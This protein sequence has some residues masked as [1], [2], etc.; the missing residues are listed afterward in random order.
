[1]ASPPGE[2]EFPLSAPAAGMPLTDSALGYFAAYLT[3]VLPELVG[4]AWEEVNPGEPLIKT[5]NTWDPEEGPFNDD[6]LP[7]LYLWKP[8][9]QFGINEDWVKEADG[10]RVNEASVV[11]MWVLPPAEESQFGLMHPF[12]QGFAD[13][14]DYAIRLGRHSAWK[15]AA[16]SDP[17]AATMGSSFTTW[18]NWTK[19]ELTDVKRAT[20]ER[21]YTDSNE[22]DTFLAYRAEIRTASL[23]TNPPIEVGVNVWPNR[24][25]MTITRTDG[26]I[27]NEC[28]TP[29]PDQ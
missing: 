27:L 8:K 24:S 14:L 15:I 25:Y 22:L 26:V 29:V 18:C 6:E 13:A 1:M 10:A 19:C 21:G 9:V 3:A 12:I 5:C 20:I 16:D 28:E 23:Q 4:A 17:L 2:P 11:A 7:A